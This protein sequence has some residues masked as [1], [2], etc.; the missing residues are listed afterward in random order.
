[1]SR[2]F[3]AISLL[4]ACLATSSQANVVTVHIFDFDYTTDPTHAQILDPVIFVGDTI[5]WVL[6]AGMHT[7]TSASSSA[8][9]WNSGMMMTPGQTFDH[10]FNQ[11]GTFDY[12]CQFHGFDPGGGPPQGM[13]GKITVQAVPEPTTVAL[14]G[15]GAVALIRRRRR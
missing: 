6:D 7:T 3:L 4:G 13:A 9:V 12:F 15:L 14:L 1:M 10:T 2:N 5:H 11:V 8:E